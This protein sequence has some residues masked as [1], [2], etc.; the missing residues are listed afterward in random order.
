MS[1]VSV[2]FPGQET[3]QVADEI[4]TEAVNVLSAAN[5]SGVSLETVAVVETP[6]PAGAPVFT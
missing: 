6:A 2:M 3:S 1:F 4:V 5:N